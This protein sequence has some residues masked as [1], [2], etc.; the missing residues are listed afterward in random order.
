MPSRQT[1]GEDSDQDQHVHGHRYSV[2][3]VAESLGVGL[4]EKVEVHSRSMTNS[5]VTTP[6]IGT[7]R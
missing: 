2:V 4:S 6:P 3:K 7:G 5:A 1:N